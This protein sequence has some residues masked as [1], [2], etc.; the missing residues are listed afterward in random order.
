L[1]ALANLM[2]SAFVIPGTQVRM[3]LDGLIG[4][5]PV[6]GDLITTAI[7]S[8]ILVEARRL[9]ASRFT[10][11]RMAMNIAVDGVFGAVPVAGDVFDVAFRANRRNVKILREH[12][13]RKAR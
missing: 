6:I 2:D 4:L 13:E 12:L 7:S 8:Y 3:G 1:D 9:G 11:A 10:L 5:V